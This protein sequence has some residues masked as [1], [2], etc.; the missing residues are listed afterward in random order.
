MAVTN[1]GKVITCTAAGDQVAMPLVVKN[2]RWTGATTA[3]HQLTILE[4]NLKASPET[5]H[6]SVAAGANYVEETLKE[7]SFPFGL[8]VDVLGSGTVDIHLA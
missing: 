6:R 4:S 8:E 3:G 5:I 7:M 2:I 1:N